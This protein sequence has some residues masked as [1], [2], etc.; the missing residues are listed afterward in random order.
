MEPQN[1]DVAVAIAELS[2]LLKTAVADI[3][4]IKNR[5]SIMDEQF[6]RKN[7]L[8]K[9]NAYIIE[10]RNAVQTLE[11]K[12]AVTNSQHRT[13]GIVG[14]VFVTLLAAFIS[15]LQIHFW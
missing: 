5:L 3:A 15:A 10:L 1:S 14:G 7:E 12:V 2:V 6:A 4:E 11:I 13:W 9:A 8:D